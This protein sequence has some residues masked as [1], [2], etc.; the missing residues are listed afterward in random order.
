LSFD[1]RVTLYCYKKVLCDVSIKIKALNSHINC[2]IYQ[3]FNAFALYYKCQSKPS[4]FF[5][6]QS[7]SATC[8]GHFASITLKVDCTIIMRI[9]NTLPPKSMTSSRTCIFV[10]SPEK[11]TGAKH[12]K[13]CWTPKL[14]KKLPSS[15]RISTSSSEVCPGDGTG[16]FSRVGAG[17]GEGE[18]GAEAA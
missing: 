7:L 4:P 9:I 1:S 6:P 11:R 15:R 14:Q 16:E 10:L 8:K 13:I 18:T 12:T 2:E 3:T 5:I 17:V